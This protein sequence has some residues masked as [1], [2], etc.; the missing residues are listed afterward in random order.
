MNI[1]KMIKTLSGLELERSER[2][3]TLV[4][5]DRYSFG[6]LICDIL[7]LLEEKSAIDTISRKE[8]LKA[9]NELEVLGSCNYKNNLYLEGVHDAKKAIKE[10]APA[11]PGKAEK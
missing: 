8:A 7:Q 4:N 2:E 9:L 11:L 6:I 5:I 3:K 1:K 10:I